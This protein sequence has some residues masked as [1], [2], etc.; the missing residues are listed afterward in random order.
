MTLV[1]IEPLIVRDFVNSLQLQLSDWRFYGSK[2]LRERSDMS[3]NLQHLQPDSQWWLKWEP[4]LLPL[5]E[6]IRLVRNVI[7]V[8]F[9]VWDQETSSDVL[10]RGTYTLR[11]NDASQ[12]CK[13]LETRQNH[14]CS[15]ETEKLQETVYLSEMFL[16]DL[17]ILLFFFIFL[18]SCTQKT[19]DTDKKKLQLK[20]LLLFEQIQS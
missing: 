11:I 9:S 12:S 10:Y 2:S 13:T 19:T 20:P 15:N 6:F 18:I 4:D 7:L 8:Q 5:M 16:L 17:T 1:F 14:T 3:N